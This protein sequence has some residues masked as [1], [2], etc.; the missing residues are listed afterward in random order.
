MITT[1][2]TFLFVFLAI[3]IYIIYSFRWVALFFF[4][5]LVFIICIKARKDIKKHG[6]G[7]IFRAF[8]KYPSRNQQ[9]RLVKNILRNKLNIHSIFEFDSELIVGI[10]R[11]GI[12]VLK[13]LEAVGRISG[14]CCDTT[15]LLK[16]GDTAIIPN[17]FLE[18]DIIEKK[19]KKEIK[20][21]VIKKIIVKKGTCIFEI[22]YTKEYIVVGMHN[23]YYQFQMFEK[24]VNYTEEQVKTIETSFSNYLSKNVKLKENACTR[25]KSKLQSK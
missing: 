25:P 21:A 24:K 8:H 16:N 5:L 10:S 4:L 17:Y 12:Y 6:S 23:F 2:F 19:I 7:S 18:L 9:L 22:P 11:G 13:V 3:V 15:L 1:I 14:D 20:N